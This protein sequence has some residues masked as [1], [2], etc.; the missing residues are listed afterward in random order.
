MN[1]FSMKMHREVYDEQ[2]NFMY[3]DNSIKLLTKLA[4]TESWNEYMFDLMDTE[5]YNNVE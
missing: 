4:T 1:M 5:S 3:F 2:N